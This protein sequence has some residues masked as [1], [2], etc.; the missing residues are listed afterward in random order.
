MPTQD[1]IIFEPNT[2]QEADAL[3]A[4]ATAL[5][6][7]FKISRKNKNNGE[8]IA[9]LNDAVLELNLIK[10]GKVKPRDARELIDEL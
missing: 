1:I 4:F 9:D 10:K 2:S 3:K 8:I 7:K 6:I 5:K